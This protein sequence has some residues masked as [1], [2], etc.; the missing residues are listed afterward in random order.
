MGIVNNY[1]KSLYPSI[2]D[3][4]TFILDGHLLDMK[5]AIYSGAALNEVLFFLAENDLGLF[6][7]HSLFARRKG[8]LKHT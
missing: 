3:A 7:A 2:K 5:N 4:I 1:D 8:V 6:F